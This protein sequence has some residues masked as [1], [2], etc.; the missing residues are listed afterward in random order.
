[1][2]VGFS[3]VATNTTVSS[4]NLFVS[5]ALFDRVGGFRDFRWNH[6]WDFALRA[7][8]LEEP[9]FV[10][11]PLYVYRLHPHNTIVESS[12]RS[13]VE[14]AGITQ[15]YLEH[16]LS[17]RATSPNPFAPGIATWGSAFV[18]AL[19]GSGIGG[20]VDPTMLRDVASSKLARSRRA[21]PV[22]TG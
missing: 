13:R 10:D 21:S 9:V 5:R 3:L 11:E 1:L 18:N 20:I 12:E 16:A 4:G 17:A 6:D 8:W 7:L 22:A 15:D 2:S 14:M 19:L